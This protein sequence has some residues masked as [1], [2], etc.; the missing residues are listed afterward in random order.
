VTQRSSLDLLKRARSTAGL[1]SEPRVLQAAGLRS[2]APQNDL[3]AAVNERTSPSPRRPLALLVLLALGGLAALAGCG[4]GT[5][6]TG[7]GGSGGGETGSTEVPSALTIGSAQKI[8]TLDPDQAADGYSE[9]IVHLLGGNLYELGPKGAVVPLLAASKSVSGDG[10]TWTFTLKPGLKFSDGSPLT[11]E[12]VVDTID[13]ANADKANL[14]LGFVAPIVKAEDPSPTEVVF[15]LSR[16][17]PSLPAVLSQP[18]MT[19]L[20][21]EGLKEGESFF[22]E[23]VSAGQY[24]LKSWGGGPKAV[25]VANPNYAGTPPAVEQLTFQTIEDF[26][27]RFAQVQSGQ[28]DFATDIPSRLLANPPAGLHGELSPHYGFV[29]LPLNVNSAPLD[30]V[31]VRR[32]ISAAI[33]RE[34]INETAWNGEITSLAG[35]WPSTMSGYDRGISTEQNLAAAEADLKGTACENG[36]TIHFMYS[37]ANPWAEPTATIISQNLKEI[38]IEIEL[39]RVDDA[40]FNTRLG[41]ID[42]QVAISFLYDYN[43]VPDGLLTYAMTADGG[44]QANFTGFEPGPDIQKTVTTALTQGGAA[45]TEALAQINT[46][47]GK[48]QP[49]VTLSDYAVGS[50]SRY[51]PSV[52]K[53]NAAGFIEV[54]RRGS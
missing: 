26:N 33:D 27:A 8:L 52:V 49:F 34:Q 45:R 37:A 6:V 46:L 18:E 4:G 43:N 17:Y 5:A 44:L 12:D 35:F 28:L 39:E 36:C 50:I 29:T 22:Q 38:G 7:A 41:E 2:P 24:M 10:L 53:S 23:P 3:E 19:I 13:R 40:T 20:P 1:R 48:Y 9:G 25:L 32:A 30:E 21:S 54:A 47:F 15:H 42:F 16:P 51:A 14:Y 11:S 31:G